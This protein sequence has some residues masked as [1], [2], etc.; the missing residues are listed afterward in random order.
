MTKVP[1]IIR[2]G[3]LEVG[4]F[5]GPDVLQTGVGEAADVAESPTK[6]ENEE[7]AGCKD[8]VH[9]PL[10]VVERRPMLGAIALRKLSLQVNV[11]ERRLEIEEERIIEDH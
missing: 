2:S 10:R 7:S 9:V 4:A 8:V 1:E 5:L 3:L 11:A 6:K